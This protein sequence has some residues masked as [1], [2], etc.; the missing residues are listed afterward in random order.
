MS[1]LNLLV[2]AGAIT[3]PFMRRLKSI[4]QATVI[5]LALGP[6]LP[7]SF[8]SEICEAAIERLS[9]TK[10]GETCIN[11]SERLALYYGRQE[12]L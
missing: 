8:L 12:L 4:G 6:F 9:K 1:R 7:L 5:L 11:A 3:M 10:F 2:W